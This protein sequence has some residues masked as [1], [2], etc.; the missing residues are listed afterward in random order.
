MTFWKRQHR[1]DSEETSGCKGFGRRKDE[2]DRA[3]RIF[4]GVRIVSLIL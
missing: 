2:T 4:R 3:L 1:G